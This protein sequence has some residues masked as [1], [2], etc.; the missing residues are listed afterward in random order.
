MARHERQM[1]VKRLERVDLR[2]GYRDVGNRPAV[3]FGALFPA[4]P[5]RC[6]ARASVWRKSA[7][8][9]INIASRGMALRSS[10]R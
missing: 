9:F 4:S 1:L 7:R 5:S 6:L 8:S 3:K 2:P 10:A